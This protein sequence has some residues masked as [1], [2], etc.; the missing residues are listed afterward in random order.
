MP[1]REPSTP[2]EDRLRGELADLAAMPDAA[3]RR[4]R[5]DALVEHRRGELAQR[6]H[7]LLGAAAPTVAVGA[8]TAWALARA[9]G[10]SS[11]RRIDATPAFRP[12]GA[13]RAAW[14]RIGAAPL[15]ERFG[16]TSVWAGD[17]LLAWSGS[18]D[19]LGESGGHP[20]SGAAWL[21]STGRWQAMAD[22]PAGA[23]AGGFGVWDGQ[24]VFLGLLEPDSAAPWKA[25]ET[26]PLYGIAAYA[27]A[28]DTWRYVASVGQVQE[29]LRG[30]AQQAVVADGG[31]VVAGRSTASPTGRHDPGLDA[32]RVDTRTGAATAI[33]P[34]PYAASPYDDGSGSI[35]LTVAADRLVATTNWD[36]RPWVLDPG[37]GSWRQVEAPPGSR[38]LHLLPGVAGGSVVYFQESDRE[39][40]HA[41]DVADGG[42]SPWR[43]VAPNPVARARWGYPPV[44]SGAELFVPGAAYDPEADR[45]RAVPAPPRGQGRQREL[46]SCW[47]DGGLLLFGGEEYDCPD[48]AR[49][50][51]ASGPDALDGWL[52]TD[53]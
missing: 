33:A 42:P 45:W 20:P 22:A 1:D 9:D 12:D 47:A 23:V 3:A 37:A 25:S 28:T 24:E 17:R 2:F 8:G 10:S 31:L 5:V 34:G 39:A 29:G 6:R 13:P 35:D 16:T 7:F 19:A 46:Q 44:W 21:P 43:S 32:F 14:H 40:W 11:Q 38:A 49:C 50:D 15:S 27:P 30:A 52:L 41:L 18:S 51:R 26:N 4:A 36:G 48:D 53:P